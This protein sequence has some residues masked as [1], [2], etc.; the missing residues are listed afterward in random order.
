MSVYFVNQGKSYNEERRGGYVWSPQYTKSGNKNAGFT[1]MKSIKQGDF[2][3]HNN[4]AKIVAISIAETNCQDAKRPVEL[5]STDWVDDG[6][7][8]DT[9]YFDINVPLVLGNHRQWLI[10]H[11]KEGSAFTVEGK[12]KQRYM[13]EIND[14]HAVYLLKETLGI[15]SDET[16]IK[17]LNEAL[18]EILFV[19]YDQLEKNEIDNLIDNV[20]EKKPEW[21]GK[22]TKQVM[23]TSSSTGREV[24]K[25]NSQ[26]AVE[27]LVRAEYLCEFNELDRTFRRKN[28]KNYTEPHHLIP[29]SKYRDFNYSVDVME[30]IISLCSHCHNLLHYGMLEEKIPILKKI[31]DERVEA[32]K[33]VGLDLTFE[34]LVEY[35]K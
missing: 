1:T 5:S 20:S 15:Q 14:E 27:A 18:T 9:K 11:Y 25:R 3:L 32:L 33:A 30:N 12:A 8:I 35:Y 7:R 22:K 28:G 17:V 31:Y 13:C 19:E 6:Y 10:E 34:Q 29:I 4:D 23:V 2:I 21:T 16:V 26:I 24:P